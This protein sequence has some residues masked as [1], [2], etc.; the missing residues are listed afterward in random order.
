MSRE[1]E[2]AVE[3]ARRAGDEILK[4]QAEQFPVDYKPGGEGPVT[5]AD[6]RADR[7]IRDGLAA[8]FPADGLLSEESPDDLRRLARS[9]VWIVDPLDGTR[10]FVQRG[11][12]FAVL[13]GLAVEG[14]AVLGVVHLPA[15]GLTYAAAEGEGAAAIPL[16][17]R[18]R[19][20]ALGPS[21]PAGAGL[22]AVVSREHYGRKTQQAVSLLHPVRVLLSGS[23]GR[24]AS[25]VA[26]GQADIY[27]TAGGR[28]RHWDA[29]ASEALVRE[30]GGVFRDARGRQLIY[31]TEQTRNSSGLL[32]C[33]RGLLDAVVAAVEAV[34]AAKGD[35]P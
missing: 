11:T 4:V 22:T 32:A 3:L 12:E 28:S 17:G 23:V 25:L 29:C 6:R 5:I 18:A 1:L 31:N 30:A 2:V 14:R 15:E 34:L 26:S 16:V 7:L 35:A 10:Q 27:L 9:R 21:P 19:R 24:K 20:L 13:I 33:R 8:A